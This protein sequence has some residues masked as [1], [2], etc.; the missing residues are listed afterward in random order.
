MPSLVVTCTFLSYT[1]STH[2]HRLSWTVAS[3][4][5]YFWGAG[6]NEARRL[7]APGSPSG[8]SQRRL[9]PPHCGGFRDIFEILCANR[10]AYILVL[11]ASL[12]GAKR[13][14]R[15]SIFI[16]GSPPLLN[17]RICDPDCVNMFVKWNVDTVWM[18][19]ETA[20]GADTYTRPTCTCTGHQQ[21]STC[22]EWLDVVGGRCV[23][24]ILQADCL[25]V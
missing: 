25:I 21:A 18:M 1:P 20:A 2:T 9:R 10:P 3:I 4:Q 22:C 12:V 23:V 15:P 16:G 13:Y 17:R 24:R 11:L 14:A 8:R 5:I 6:A 19:I 7:E